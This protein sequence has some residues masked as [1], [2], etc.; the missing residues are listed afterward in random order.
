MG[1]MGY[2]CMLQV[3][4]GALAGALYEQPRCNEVG[5]GP[6]C[7]TTPRG[8]GAVAEV[9]GFAISLGYGAL[10]TVQALERLLRINPPNQNPQA[11]PPK[12]LP[13]TTLQSTLQSTQNSNPPTRRSRPPG[14]T[15]TD[16]GSRT[17]CVY[18][19]PHPP[20]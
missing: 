19:P 7:I 11:A 13:I 10:R 15:T 17:G 9:A 20:P 18:S 5:A 1:E 6:W 12:Q 4:V 14:V 3:H 16:N 8:W 2:L